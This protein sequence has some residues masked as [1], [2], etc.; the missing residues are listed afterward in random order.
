MCH[1][2]DTRAERLPGNPANMVVPHSA[3]G[4]PCRRHLLRPTLCRGSP[5]Q[6]RCRMTPQRDQPYLHPLQGDPGVSLLPGV[7]SPN[8]SLR[9]GTAPLEGG[10]GHQV[11]VQAQIGAG[12]RLGPGALSEFGPQPFFRSLGAW[13]AGALKLFACSLPGAGLDQG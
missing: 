12:R 6:W 1:S 4:P 5:G 7:T 3:L 8:L 10:E 2:Q 11:A 13:V 9:V